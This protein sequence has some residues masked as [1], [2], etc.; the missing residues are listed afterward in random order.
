MSF[1]HQH[2][3]NISHQNLCSPY[4]ES[5]SPFQLNFSKKVHRWD[6]E[7]CELKE[8]IKFD[9]TKQ[10]VELGTTNEFKKYVVTNKAKCLV[11]KSQDAVLNNFFTAKISML[12]KLN[13]YLSRN[14]GK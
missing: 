12:A 6:Y 9:K 3:K 5:K 7:I 10:P 11:S 1:G 13:R 8:E 14:G 4:S 2:P